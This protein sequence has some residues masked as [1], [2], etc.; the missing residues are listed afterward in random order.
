MCFIVSFVIIKGKRVLQVKNS[1]GKDL[2]FY[3]LGLSL[4][5]IGGVMK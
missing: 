5:V 1:V 2:G 4:L 3:G